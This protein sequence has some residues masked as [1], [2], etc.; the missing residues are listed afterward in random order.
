MKKKIFFYLLIVFQLCTKQSI[1]FENKIILK[2][3]DKI[4]TTFDIKQEE[5]HLLVLN[6]KLNNLDQNQLKFIARDSIIKEKIKEIELVKYY[7]IESVLD[8]AN[9]KNIIKNLY[10]TAGFQKEKEFV[11]YLES[12]NLKFSS[13]KRKLAIEML[14]NNLI[15]E[16]F[17]NRVVIDK[18]EMKN[19]IEKE[20]KNLR[21]TRDI[22]LSEILIRNSKDLK[23]DI[24]Y[25]EILKSIKDVGF[26]TTANIFSISDT[27]KIG[28]KVG[29][30]KET[31]LS[32]KIQ[33]N[34]FNLGKG[35]ITKPI[36]INEN[37]LILSID[38]TKINKQKIDKNKILSNRIS[39]E[40]NQQLERFSLAYFE[41]IKQ[42]IQINEF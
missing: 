38:D 1:S 18:V 26:S 27:A 3:N 9:L 16:K 14:W 37:F 41:K 42:N 25:S 40:R 5:K 39:Y 22:L 12:Q 28:G 17:N 35:Q 19:N 8:D 15:F 29:W 30:V 31:S 21:F 23:L 33:Q 6:P 36:K 7:K 24:V 20:I 32:K 11:K 13:V 4:I 2:I 34:T 10:Q